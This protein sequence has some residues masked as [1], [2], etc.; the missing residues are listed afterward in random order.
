MTEGPGSMPPSPPC[1]LL[2]M[3]SECGRGVEVPLPMDRESLE[4]FLILQTWFMGVFTSPGQVPIVFGALC[5]D[6]APKVFSPEALR[7][8]EAH[9]Q[10]MLRG[11]A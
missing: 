8:A 7:A 2:V 6:C 3:C 5:G 10:K 11:D 4:L 1:A 9:R